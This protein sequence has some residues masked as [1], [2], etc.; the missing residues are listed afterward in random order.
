[1]TAEDLCGRCGGCLLQRDVS[2]RKKKAGESL[3]HFL[4]ADE[5]LPTMLWARERNEEF[6]AGRPVPMPRR[7]RNR[8]EL[9]NVEVEKTLE[10]SSDSKSGCVVTYTCDTG[11]FIRCYPAGELTTGHTYIYIYIYIYMHMLRIYVYIWPGH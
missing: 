7:S 6:E 4:E 9:N 10:D 11:F 5:Q 2:R 1:M 3:I 8:K